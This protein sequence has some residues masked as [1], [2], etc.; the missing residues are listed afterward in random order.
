MDYLK[1]I[2]RHEASPFF[3]FSIGAGRIESSLTTKGHL[4]DM[5]AP[6][7]YEEFKAVLVCT[8]CSKFFNF[9][10][11]IGTHAISLLFNKSVPVV[12]IEKDMLQ[13]FVSMCS[14]YNE[15]KEKGTYRS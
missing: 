2:F 7:A 11:H 10:Y 8:T 13:I 6:F 15:F 4:S 1:H 9:F 14:F 3:G 12:V 5:M